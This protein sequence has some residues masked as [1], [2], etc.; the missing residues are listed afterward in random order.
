MKAKMFELDLEYQKRELRCIYEG[1]PFL[2]KIRF[3]LLEKALEEGKILFI[4]GAGQPA[5]R[6]KRDFKGLSAGTVL[7]KD[8]F[9]PGFPHIPRIFCLKTGL[10]RYMSGPFYAEEKIEGYNVR[11]VNF[12]GSIL[13]FTRRGY[14]CPF[15]TDRWPDFLPA[16]PTFFAEYPDYALCCEVAGPENPFVTEYPPYIK[17]DVAFFV[18]DVID[19]KRQRF[20]PPEEKYALL[21]R[22]GFR[23]PEI[24]GPFWASEVEALKEL[25]LRYDQEG[26]E[27]LVFKPV[28]KGR[29]IKYVTSASNLGDLRVAFPFIGELEASYI[30]HRLVRLALGRWELGQP[31]DESFYKDL[32]QA[33]FGEMNIILDRVK[34]KKP[35]EEIFRIRLRREESLEALLAHFRAARVRIEIH[36]V[37][38]KG[39]YWCVEFAKIYPRAT[40][41]W[42]NK[43]EG[44]AQID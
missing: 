10:V 24:S 32:G 38:K 6:V 22:F 43:I 12:F 37:E 33:L 9:L 3:G 35:V 41:F 4:E 8:F 34:A 27:G 36:K 30:V 42:A 20:L 23:T 18:F 44:L 25:I 13:A 14:I 7:A 1:A 15:A 26:R 29:V 5:F 16:L 2:R 28:G 40:S 17:E 19:L 39:R 11:L 21:R 31:F